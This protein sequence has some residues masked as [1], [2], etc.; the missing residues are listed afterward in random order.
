MVQW[1]GLGAFTAVA[2]GSI[3]GGEL[4]SCK[5]HGA[6]KKKKSKTNLFRTAE[7]SSSLILG[8]HCNDCF[9]APL[10]FEAKGQA[11]EAPRWEG[12]RS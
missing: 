10:G 2:R 5:P 12:M 1:L 7:K 6:A 3:P 8:H 4:G 9:P 11:V